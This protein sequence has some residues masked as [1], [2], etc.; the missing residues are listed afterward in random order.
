MAAVSGHSKNADEDWDAYWAHG[1][2][3]SCANAFSGNYAGRIRATWDAFFDELPAGARLLDIATGNGAIAL[4]ASEYSLR[5]DKGFEVHGIDRAR[6]DPASAWRGDEAVLQGVRFQ[7]RISAERLPFDDG[8]FQAVTGQYALEY[9][10]YPAT[11]AELGRVISPG[12][13]ARFVLHHPDSVV[14]NTS[15]EEHSHGQLLLHETRIFDKARTLLGRIVKATEDG[16]RGAL[17]S[18]SEA[19][20][21]RDA[22]NQAAARISAAAEKTTEPDLLTT[23]LGHI[24]QAFK[25]ASG[26]SA[27]KNALDALSAGEKEVRA[28]LA[29][30]EDLLNAV[31]DDSKMAKMRALFEAASFA[32]V[33]PVALYFK[34]ENKEL[35]MGWQLDCRRRK[36][37]KPAD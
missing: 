12:G 3:T 28:N 9:T 5:N 17:A 18:D 16:E 37:N 8:F 21:E 10:D 6:I 33:D 34:N 23:A 25:A 32:T 7:G 13:S 26:P 22:L 15:R 35:L 2:L 24:S 4:L 11:I 27:S 20:A 29:R 31:V 1:F 19:Q 36:S 14:I 30:L